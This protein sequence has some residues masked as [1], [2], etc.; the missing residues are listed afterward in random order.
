MTALSCS[1]TEMGTGAPG[2]F[3]II[4][5]PN[6]YRSGGKSGDQDA[7]NN[8]ITNYVQNQI[9]RSQNH[10]PIFSCSAV[11]HHVLHVDNYSSTD[12][13]LH[14]GK[15]HHLEDQRCH[16][17]NSQDDRDAQDDP[18]SERLQA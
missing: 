5:E 6:T 11:P 18:V 15:H 12:Q 13:H 17:F 8:E 2:A 4:Q 14:V 1:L 7:G 16:L 3:Q 9:K 10:P